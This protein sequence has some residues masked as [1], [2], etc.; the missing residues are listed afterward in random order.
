M[1]VNL[2]ASSLGRQWDGQIVTD[3]SDQ[4]E[5]DL[6][7]ARDFGLPAVRR[8]LD[9]RVTAALADENAAVLAEMAKQV[10]PFHRTAPVLAFMDRVMV[11]LNTGLPSEGFALGFGVGS[12]RPSST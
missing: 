9:D 11:S 2:L 10:A 12:A 4:A 1:G 5:L 6:P 7:V 3:S 8:V